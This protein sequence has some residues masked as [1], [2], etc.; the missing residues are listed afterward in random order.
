MEN[1]SKKFVLQLKDN[2]KMFNLL[3]NAELED[4]FSYFEKVTCPAGRAFFEEGD[5]GDSIGFLL[6]GKLEV[7][8]ETEFKG[9]HIILAVLDKG[10]MVGEFSMISGQQR[11]ATVIALEDSEILTLKREPLDAFLEKSPH[12]GIKVF[13]G[14]V[15]I[16][17]LRF[18]KTVDRLKVIF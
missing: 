10:A 7:K 2:L 1:D 8:K 4:F 13:K 18:R 11:S 16:M 14:I 12:T 3:D 6:S 17:G 5:P 9:K 15:H